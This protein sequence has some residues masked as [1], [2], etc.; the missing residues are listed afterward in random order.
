MTRIYPY[1]WQS[2]LLWTKAAIYWCVRCI[3]IVWCCTI[4]FVTF[5]YINF[6]ST[7]S[8]LHEW[9]KQF[10]CFYFDEIFTEFETRYTTNC[11]QKIDHSICIV[12]TIQSS[13]IQLSVKWQL[14]EISFNGF[15]LIFY[16]CV[17]IYLFSLLNFLCIC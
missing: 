13:L 9:F 11:I 5:L 14:Q 8:F 17:S 2:W 6:Q 7:Y 12:Y 10:T 15:S 4:S 3:A 16:L 1:I